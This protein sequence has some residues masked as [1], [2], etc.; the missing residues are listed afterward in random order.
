M[1]VKRY[2]MKQKNIK[3]NKERFILFETGSIDMMI[4]KNNNVQE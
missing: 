1:K 3:R 2:E 4:E